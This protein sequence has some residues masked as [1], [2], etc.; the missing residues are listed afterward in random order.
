MIGDRSATIAAS[1][2]AQRKPR[3]LAPRRRITA[4]AT[5]HPR[6]RLA[7]AINHSVLA[8]L[9]G[10]LALIFIAALIYLS[11]AGQV[12]VMQYSIAG[13]QRQQIALQMQY[14]NLYA[15]ATGLQSL[16][17]VE[18]IAITKL[19]MSKPSY[20]G[21][22]I[23]PAVPRLPVPLQDPTSS[24]QSQSQPLAWMDHAVHVIAA[25]L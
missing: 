25:Q 21:L 6:Q 13:L 24:A 3:T 15:T 4:L 18:T 5:L 16:Q 9:I 2:L 22:W 1:P 11:Q 20:S 17:R 8:Q 14:S 7:E 23:Q 12:S 19:H 10:V